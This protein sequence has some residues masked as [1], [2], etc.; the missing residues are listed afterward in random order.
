MHST[1]LGFAVGLKL[2]CWASRFA[3]VMLAAFGMLWSIARLMFLTDV[4]IH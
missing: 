2:D 1:A 4:V 3:M